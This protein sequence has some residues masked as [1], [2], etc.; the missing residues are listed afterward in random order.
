[1][2]LL[3]L[4]SLLSSLALVNTASPTIGLLQVSSPFRKALHFAPAWF[5]AVVLPTGRT[6][7]EVQYAGDACQCLVGRVSV[8][9]K[10]ALVDRGQC[11]FLQKAIHAEQAG[12][13]AMIIVNDTNDYFIMTDDG[14]RRNVGLHSF[15]VS[16]ADGDAIKAAL[17]C[18]PG[19]QTPC[20]SNSEGVTVSYGLGFAVRAHYRSF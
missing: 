6:T 17:P 20:D 15:L 4:F 18:S 7:A 8:R 10:I 1:M 16:K 11:S 2:N 19:Q 14:T 12:A 9:N 13:L 5:G 3:L